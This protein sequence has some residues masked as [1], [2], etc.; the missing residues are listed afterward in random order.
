M[1]GTKKGISWA[2]GMDDG[3]TQVLGFTVLL[4]C[5]VLHFNDHLR[6]K[7]RNLVLQLVLQACNEGLHFELHAKV[8]DSVR[9]NLKFFD[10]IL[11]CRRLSNMHELSHV[12]RLATSR[13]KA[14]NDKVTALLPIVD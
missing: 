12:P 7:G 8:M 6:C 11:N 4:Q 3:L 1:A 2:L 10:V 14:I 13:V 5:E 9:K